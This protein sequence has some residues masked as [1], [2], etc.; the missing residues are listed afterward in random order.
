MNSFALFNGIKYDPETYQLPSELK[1][2]HWVCPICFKD[3]SMDETCCH[4]SNNLK[5]RDVWAR[6]IGKELK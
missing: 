2:T 3:I 6:T 4:H 5:K 1:A